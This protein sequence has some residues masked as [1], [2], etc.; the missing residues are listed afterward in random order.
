[1]PQSN[2]KT[3]ILIWLILGFIVGAAVAATAI[4]I[5]SPEAAPQG[6]DSDV[7]FTYQGQGFGITQL[8]P[9]LA[10]ELNEINANTYNQKMRILEQ[11]ALGMHIA[12]EAEQRNV[13]PPE[14]AE[15]LLQV[16]P[17]SDQDVQRFYRD[18]ASQIGVP[19]EQV[20]DQIRNFLAQQRSV[21]KQQALVAQLQAEGKLQFHVKR[22]VSPSV[23]IDTAG[24]PSKG[25]PSA[26]VTV[27]A[28]SDYQ[29]PHCKAAAFTLDRLVEENPEKVQLIHMDFPIN[30]SGISR[31]IAEGSYCAMQQNQFW[32][33]HQL[34]YSH[35]RGL[36]KESPLQFAKELELD[37]ASFESCLTSTEA[38]QYVRSSEQQAIALGLRGTPAIFINGQRFQGTDLEKSLEQA[39]LTAAKQ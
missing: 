20:Q 9:A 24:R 39:V 22:P 13:A 2:S 17:P 37:L 1:M 14:V 21:E 6:E 8:P 26:P 33:Y 28:F 19:F 34:A 32:A 29:C 23:S 4:K 30:S 5:N 7:L 12:R 10:N 3:S 25:E 15:E 11:A 18:N 36:T 38:R 35:Q 31:V 16:T 27:I